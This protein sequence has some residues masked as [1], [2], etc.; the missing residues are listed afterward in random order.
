MIWNKSYA[1][2]HN[3]VFFA[4]CTHETTCQGVARVPWAL[5]GAASLAPDIRLGYLYS[6][7]VT[8]WAALPQN[9]VDTLIGYHAKLEITN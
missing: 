8:A 9:K 6:V 7:N 3:A 5:G 1:T 2:F 4:L